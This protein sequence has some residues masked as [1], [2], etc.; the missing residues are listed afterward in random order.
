MEA[1]F[2]EM[3]GNGVIPGKINFRATDHELTGLGQQK[4]VLYSIIT[5]VNRET[6]M[7]YVIPM[8]E[9]TTKALMTRR[10][11]L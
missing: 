1:G 7:L 2:D 5:L 6:Q 9:F 10:Q 3:I 8:H 4:G 11:M